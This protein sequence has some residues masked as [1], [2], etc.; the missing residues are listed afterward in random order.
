MWRESRDVV[1]FVQAYHEWSMTLG[2]THRCSLHSCGIC[3]CR[4]RRSRL[5][6]NE[7]RYEGIGEDA[8]WKTAGEGRDELKT[9]S[10]IL[11]SFADTEGLRVRKI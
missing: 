11:V 10:G 5:V 7:E 4:R 2:A 6:I 1:I 8:L 9:V 3:R